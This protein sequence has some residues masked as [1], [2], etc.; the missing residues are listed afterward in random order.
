MV[1]ICLFNARHIFSCVWLRVCLA[2]LRFRVICYLFKAKQKQMHMAIKLPTTLNFFIIIII[3]RVSSIEM[4]QHR[5]GGKEHFD[6]LGHEMQVNDAC[7][8]HTN[9]SVNV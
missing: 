2:D 3:V 7:D 4:G 1:E 8:A 5:N 6:Q 9:R